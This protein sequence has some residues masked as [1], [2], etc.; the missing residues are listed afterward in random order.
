MPHPCLFI[1]LPH[2]SEGAPRK[3]ARCLEVAWVTV[4]GI[5]VVCPDALEGLLIP[6][7][8][9]AAASCSCSCSSSLLFGP[10]LDRP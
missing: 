5:G 10:R 3:T 8:P 7:H 4:W 1:I 6:I 9:A 2:P